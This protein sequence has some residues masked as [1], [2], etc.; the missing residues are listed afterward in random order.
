[1]QTAQLKEADQAKRRL[2]RDLAAYRVK[3]LF[4]SP[5]T[6]GMRV[7][8]QE[9]AAPTM[10]QLRVLGQA[11]LDIERAVLV[12]T[13]AEGGGLLV[14]AAEGSGADAGKLVRESLSSVGGK[15]G[16]SPRLA[17]GTAPSADLAAKA[18]ELIRAELGHDR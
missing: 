7:V 5:P 12:A 17:Q 3:A 4:D 15:G 14:A 9:R 18:L 2:E 10:D 11:T 8:F 1:S 6:P 13:A 16:G